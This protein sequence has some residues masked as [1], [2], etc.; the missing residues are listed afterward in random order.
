MSIT[1][2]LAS[3]AVHDLSR[4]VEYYQRLFGRPADSTPMPE[5]AEWKFERD[6][7]LQVY[8]LE[9]RAG[10]GST[11]YTFGRLVEA[12]DI[13]SRACV[14]HPPGPAFARRARKAGAMHWAR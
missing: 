1:N 6:G 2:A 14:S 9:E 4:S 3:L 10:A 11:E 7:W 13:G 5:V 8:Q 12:G